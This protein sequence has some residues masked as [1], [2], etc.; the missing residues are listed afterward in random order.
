[1]IADG[2]A[3]ERATYVANGV[4][5]VAFDTSRRPPR[6][7]WTLG[8]VALFRPRKGIEVLLEALAQCREAGNDVRLRA[9]GPSETQLYQR[10]VMRLVDRW[11]LS[12]AIDWT[13]FTD[14]VHAELAKVYREVLG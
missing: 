12:D 3:P 9:V 2:F 7:V 11:Q 8:M 14:D 1:M 13:G 4:P 10:E 6:S 5:G